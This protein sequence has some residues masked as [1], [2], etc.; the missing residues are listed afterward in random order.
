VGSESPPYVRNRRVG[1]PCPRVTFA[2]T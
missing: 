1:T 2:F